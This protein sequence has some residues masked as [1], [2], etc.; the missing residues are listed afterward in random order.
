MLGSGACKKTGFGSGIAWLL[1]AMGWMT[2]QLL[3]ASKEKIKQIFNIYSP[4]K[5]SLCHSPFSSL[6]LRMYLPL[7]SLLSALKVP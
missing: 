7:P 5:I 6:F 1:L 4:I 2:A 3:K